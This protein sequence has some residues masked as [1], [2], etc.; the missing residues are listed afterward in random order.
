M[1]TF[2]KYPSLCLALML[3]AAVLTQILAG[4][5]HAQGSISYDEPFTGATLNNPSEWISLAGGSLTE[6]PCL[7]AAATAISVSVGTVE[8]CVNQNGPPTVAEG[9]GAMRLTR[10]RVLNDPNAVAGSLLY[11]AALDASEGMDIS[12]S[13][14]MESGQVADG[15]SFFLKDGDNATDAIGTAG[16]ALGY[17]MSHVFAGGLQGPN[18]NGV[19]GAL[20][21]IG[22]DKYGNFS[23]QGIASADCSNRGVFSNFGPQPTTGNRL[24][25]R[26]PDTSLA[27]DGSAGYCY[28]AETTV[29]YATD[30]QRVRIVVPPYTPGTS[31]MVSVYLASHTTPSLLPSTPTLT[32]AITSTA[33]SFKFGFSAATGWWSNNHELRDLQIRPAG[34][35]ITSV[36]TSTAGGEGTGPTSGGTL[37]TITGTNIDAGATVTVDGQACTDVTVSSGGTQLTCITPP[38]SLGTKQVVITNPNGGPGF[39]TFTYVNPA[40]TVT[41]VNPGSGDPA[42]GNTVTIVG[43]GFEANATA[44]LGGQPC[45]NVVVLS[46]TQL[47]CVAPAGTDGAV[48]DATVTNVGSASGT[49]TELYTYQ[50][51]SPPV[52]VSVFNHPLWV[53]ILGLLMLSLVHWVT[54]NSRSIH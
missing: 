41:E 13:I 35:E 9:D 44:T 42:G 36:S 23:W 10:Q 48:V 1:R 18:G 47:T 54:I 19:P 39:A 2:P 4:L 7:T 25:I 32:Q 52:P 38:G 43:T 49:G 30:F 50:T 40:P 16:G 6:Y 17:G 31:T 14:R 21:G 37:L 46:S 5:A 45:T 20:F 3:S 53:L 15:M 11:T 27:Q 51:A 28:L 12:F 26:G 29:T 8:A 34:A 22:F 33:T 24:V